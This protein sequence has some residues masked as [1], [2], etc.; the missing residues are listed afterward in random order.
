M[1]TPEIKPANICVSVV[2]HLHGDELFRLLKKIELLCAVNVR[3]VILTLNV[4]E[5][6]LLAGVNSKSWSFAMTVIENDK[7]KGFG[8]NHNSAFQLSTTPYFCVLNPDIDLDENPFL[9]LL[10]AFEDVLTG[11]AFPVQLGKDGEIQDYAR[12]VPSPCALYSRHFGKSVMAVRRE[13]ADWINGAFMLYD[14]KIFSLLRGFDTRY[15]MYCED[16]DIC[17][18]IQLAGLK[19][20]QSHAIVVHTARRN[21]RKNLRHLVWHVTSL[22]R[23]WASP[24]YRKFYMYQRAL[25]SDRR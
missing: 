20:C 17:L 7:P 2:S 3:Q 9:D 11:C 23:L 12:E 14:A 22:L 25:R 18:R 21:T 16:V 6:V 10:T 8:D 15:F 1:T 4:P 13:D 24:T 19:L 5:P